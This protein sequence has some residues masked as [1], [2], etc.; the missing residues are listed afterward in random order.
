MGKNLKPQRNCRI[1]DELYLKVKYIADQEKR[2]FNNFIEITL[3][4][5]VADYETQHGIIEVD[6]DALYE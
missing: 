3:T 4:R 6:T 5:I 1:D 2:S